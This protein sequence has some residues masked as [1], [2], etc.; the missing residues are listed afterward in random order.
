[1]VSCALPYRTTSPRTLFS[2]LLNARTCSA[3]AVRR[4]DGYFVS[5]FGMPSCCCGRR[6]RTDV[7]NAHGWRRY[8]GG[9][10]TRQRSMSL[11]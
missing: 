5:W 2:T 11:L 1:V 4:Q 6:G 9:R 3:A 10:R 7:K 8:G